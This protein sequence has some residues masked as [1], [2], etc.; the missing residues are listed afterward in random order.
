MV[1]KFREY[2]WGHQCVVWTDNNP[3]SHLAKLG[4]TEWR[5]V[6]DLSAFVY[7]DRYQLGCRN[8]NADALSRLPAYVALGVF[9]HFWYEKR[10]PS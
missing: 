4:A 6:T 1:E 8:K 2:L 3:L 7:T 5:W 9:H 10:L